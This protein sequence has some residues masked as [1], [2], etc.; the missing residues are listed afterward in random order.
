M[1][2]VW[3]DM[4]WVRRLSIV[5]GT[6]AVLGVFAGM[7]FLGVRTQYA[8]LLTGLSPEDAA[9]VTQFLD[10]SNEPYRLAA[11]GSA[12]LVDSDRVY[13]LRLRL[14]GNGLPKGGTV[15]LEMF[16][17]PSMTMSRF[18]EQ[19]NYRRG[20]EGELRRTIRQMDTVKDARVHIVV[21]ERRLFKKQ[22]EPSRASVT[23]NLHSG[24]RLGTE[25]VDAITHLVAAAV[26][27]L[28]AQQVTVVDSD[29]NILARG[30]EGSRALDSALEHQREVEDTLSERVRTLVE[31]AV[32]YGNSQVTVS[33]ELDFDQ[34]EQRSETF[35]P[36]AVAIRSEQSN[37]Q[38]QAGGGAPG[39]AAGVPGTRT[40]LA[41]GED[42]QDSETLPP[43]VGRRSLTKNY[44][45]SKSTEL[46][47]SSGAAITRLSV[48]VLVNENALKAIAGDKPTEQVIGSIS[49]IVRKAVGYRAERGDQVVVEAMSFVS[50]E[51]PEAEAEPRWLTLVKQLWLPVAGALLAIA[52]LILAFVTRRAIR[53]AE[54]KLLSE[55]K[56]VRDL[57]AVIENR[58]PNAIGAP[59]AGALPS[60]LTTPDPDRAL[61]V[62]KTW[63]AEDSEAKP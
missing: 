34:R 14:A 49:E 8:P 54:A 17:D 27:G 40:N 47:V 60:G 15:G 23:V 31:R 18:A 28:E 30:G 62:I 26:P 43:G 11:G 56:T 57:E 21:P 42:P 4:S 3:S 29:G 16:D 10:D 5:G 45:I 44:E 19:L 35:D 6:L 12:V 46:R 58:F 36:D 38:A 1:G 48:A 22:Q 59:A 53:R 7:I 32:G 41:G 13:D 9:E 50:T 20:L 39:Q 2:T 55:P 25:Q 24:R 61:A 52:G 63:L 51:V 33:A 37:A